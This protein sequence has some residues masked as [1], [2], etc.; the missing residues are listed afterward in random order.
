[1]AIKT[2]TNTDAGM[3]V[4]FIVIW[5]LHNASFDGNFQIIQTK[6]AGISMEQINK[7]IQAKTFMEMFEIPLAVLML[8]MRITM[9][10]A[11][12]PNKEIV[13]NK[14]VSEITEGK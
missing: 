9:I 4:A 13:V 14:M 3:M 7:S 6:V 5:I 12:I 8:N 1:M 11:R 2:S 10:F